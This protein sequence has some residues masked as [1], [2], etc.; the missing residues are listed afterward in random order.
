MQKC[1]VANQMLNAY[2]LEFVKRDFVLQSDSAEVRVA[3]QA[4]TQEV[5]NGIQACQREIL[6]FVNTFAEHGRNI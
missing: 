4:T 5:Q 6:L 3:T 2:Q 1:C